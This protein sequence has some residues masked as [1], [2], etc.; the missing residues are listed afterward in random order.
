M[1]SINTTGIS[2]DELLLTLY[3]NPAKNNVKI[4]FVLPGATDEA[5]LHIYDVNGK[6]MN[7]FNLK[8]KKGAEL[9]N[10][11]EYPNGVYYY[12]LSCKTCQMQTGKLVIIK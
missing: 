7:A 5:L 11:S 12:K 4:E 9:L 8:G 3:P 10:T 1:D 6:A 2:R